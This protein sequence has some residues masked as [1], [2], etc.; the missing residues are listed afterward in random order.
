MALFNLSLRTRIYTL[1]V[2]LMTMYVANFALMINVKNQTNAARERIK[3]TNV[4][5][6][7]KSQLLVNLIDAETGQR[8]YILTGKSEYLAPYSAGSVKVQTTLKN[9][10]LLNKNV[11]P[12]HQLLQDVERLTDLKLSELAQTIQLYNL[13]EVQASLDLINS[14]DG[15]RY[16]DEIRAHLHAFEV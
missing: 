12:Q 9:L 7:L 13:G 16:M 3:E 2:I 6:T 11:G 10:L 5:L 8:G 4:I 1:F 15:Q 14:D